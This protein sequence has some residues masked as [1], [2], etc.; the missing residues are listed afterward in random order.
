MIHLQIIAKTEMQMNT[1]KDLLLLDLFTH[2]VEI[3]WNRTRYIRTGEKENVHKLSCL[4]KATFFT[5]IQTKLH[6]HFDDDEVQIFGMPLSHF[7]WSLT[8]NLKEE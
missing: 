8:K 7:D 6:D 3:D 5:Q 2:S 4:T 1:I